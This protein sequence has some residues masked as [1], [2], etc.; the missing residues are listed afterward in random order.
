M[1]SFCPI[2]RLLLGIL[3]FVVGNIK[4]VMLP[5]VTCI[6]IID[7]PR[8][9]AA[10]TPSPSLAAGTT[11]PVKIYVSI[12]SSLTMMSIVTLMN[13][14]MVFHIAVVTSMM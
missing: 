1:P 9:I 12:I 5:L 8:P 2:L 7:V 3:F 10:T 13:T 4:M 11:A 14:A 6:A